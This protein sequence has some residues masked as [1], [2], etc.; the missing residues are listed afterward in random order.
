MAINLSQI[1]CIKNFVHENGKAISSIVV[2]SVSFVPRSGI[3]P[4][5]ITCTENIALN[6]FE[7]YKT[8][9]T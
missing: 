6:L 1:Q 5:V 4:N 7:Y 8:G 3:T 9:K 2:S